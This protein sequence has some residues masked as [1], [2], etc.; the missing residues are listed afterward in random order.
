MPA[1]AA[2]GFL[3]Q[4]LTTFATLASCLQ[5]CTPTTSQVG[6]IGA[7]WMEIAGLPAR[8]PKPVDASNAFVCAPLSRFLPGSHEHCSC[9]LL[10]EQAESFSSC[11]VIHTC[12]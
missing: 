12:L 1:H 7:V 4:P 9:L 8:K 11:G 5:A 2:E 6:S 3:L 10:P